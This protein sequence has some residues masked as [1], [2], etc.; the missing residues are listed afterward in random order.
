MTRGLNIEFQQDVFVVT[1]AR[2]FDLSQD[3]THQL[4]RIGRRCCGIAVTVF[5]AGQDPLSL[6]ATA[7]NGFNADAVLGVFGVKAFDFSLSLCGNV[8]HADQVKAL[9][10]ALQQQCLGLAFR[11]ALGQLQSMFGSHVGQGTLS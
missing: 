5:G 3:F 4:S 7:T 2:G 9:S 10:V 6:T 11:I 1:D 8:V